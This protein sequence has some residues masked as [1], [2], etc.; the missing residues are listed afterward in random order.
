MLR[1]CECGAVCLLAGVVWV[2]GCG[3][4]ARKD[5][6]FYTSGSRDADQRAEQRVAR[7]QQAQGKAAREASESGEVQATLYERLGGDEGIARIV[8]D[9]V[10]RLVADP[11]V[12]FERTGVIYTTTWTKKSAAW[13]ATPQRLR[14]IKTYFTQ[15]LSL[16]T[17]GPAKYTGPDLKG[18]TKNLRFTNAQFDAGIGDLKSSLDRLGVP[19]PE[20]KELL[21]IAESTRP[22]VVT[23]R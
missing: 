22:Q 6:G 2:A 13:E 18:A 11:R 14:E 15:F 3:E 20:Q 12:N 8:D 5:T 4:T 21:A 16:A 19:I 23:E 10:D 1:R 17:G 9:Y 7:A